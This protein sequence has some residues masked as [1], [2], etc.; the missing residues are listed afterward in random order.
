MSL[1]IRVGIVD[2]HPGVRV[3]LRNLLANAADIVVV[4]EGE[5]GLEAILLAKNVNPDVLL[6]DVELP[7]MRGDIV[8]QQLHESRINTKVLAVSSYNDPAYVQGMLENGAAGYITK[9]EAPSL[10]VDAI[11]GIV[12]D[13]L[14]WLS[15]AVVK[16]VSNIILGDIDFTGRELEALRCIALGKSDSEIMQRVSF[17]ETQFHQLL[18]QLLVKLDVSSR[19]ELRS[20][21]ECVL[22]T[23][24]SK[25]LG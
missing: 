4:G 19:E 6:L 24:I 12:D 17:T 1:P 18:D 2:D 25:C 23:I 15:P 8:M 5:N 14:K 3:G 22:T 7:I 13:Q 20:A 10:L 16:K 9:E 21:A 11:H